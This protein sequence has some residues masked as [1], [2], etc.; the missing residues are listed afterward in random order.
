M[1]T[2]DSLLFQR[3]TPRKLFQFA[4]QSQPLSFALY[5]AP[6]DVNLPQRSNYHRRFR[7]TFAKFNWKFVTRNTRFIH[8]FSYFIANQKIFTFQFSDKRI[9]LIEI[10]I[11]IPCLEFV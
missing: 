4:R 2:R 7:E 1:T 3:P 5:A 10:F 11:I 8:G 6:F 9:F